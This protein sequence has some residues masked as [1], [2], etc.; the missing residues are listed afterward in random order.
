[1]AMPGSEGADDREDL[2][3]SA[4]SRRWFGPNEDGAFRPLTWQG[5]TAIA[6]YVVLV[7]F[8]LVLYSDVTLIV[9]VVIIYTAVLGF[10]IAYTSDLMK[11]RFPPAG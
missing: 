6:L 9:T 11:D 8:A 7:I 5:K 3:D 2:A 1:M 4:P 10:L